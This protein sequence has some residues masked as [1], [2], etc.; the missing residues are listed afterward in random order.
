MRRPHQILIGLLFVGA[1]FGCD[2]VELTIGVE[3]GVS[4]S[5]DVSNAND[6]EWTGARLLAEAVE[7]DNS[8]TVCLDREIAGWRPGETIS[9]PKCGNK[10]RF[11]LTTGGQTARFAY[12]NGRLY[13]VFGRKEVPV[14]GS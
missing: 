9:I 3:P 1:V 14:P 4:G 6:W 2:S 10:I 5:L 8:T 11:T 13:R 12:A 7:S